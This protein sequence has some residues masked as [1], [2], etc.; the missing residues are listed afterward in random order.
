MMPSSVDAV[1]VDETVEMVLD[2]RNAVCEV[3]AESMPFDELDALLRELASEIL[4]T[5]HAVTADHHNDC[6]VGVAR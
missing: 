3:L 4:D 2:S 6:G 5:Y 1:L